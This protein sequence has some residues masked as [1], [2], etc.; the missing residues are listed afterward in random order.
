MFLSRRCS[1]MDRRPDP[2]LARL[3][4]YALAAWCWRARSRI[5]CSP[6][7]Y[8]IPQWALRC[9]LE[10]GRASPRMNGDGAGSCRRAQDQIPPRRGGPRSTALDQRGLGDAPDDGSTGVRKGSRVKSQR[11]CKIRAKF[12]L[13]DQVGDLAVGSVITN[14]MAQLRA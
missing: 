8:A 9:R 14:K 6:T 5:A 7:K 11:V 4:R 1:L 2:G 12:R 10:S 13:R 3:R